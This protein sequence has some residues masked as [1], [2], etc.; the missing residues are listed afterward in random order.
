MFGSFRRTFS[1]VLSVCQRTV[2]SN[3]ARI[4]FFANNG[5]TGQGQ[6]GALAAAQQPVRGATYGMEYQP[7]NY[8]RK[9]RHGF[10]KRV[11]TRAG[12][13]ILKR[14]REKGRKFLSH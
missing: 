11:R 13:R 10:L 4:G 5:L 12:R 3:T 1:T 7:N 8:K 6:V 9:K 2:F 14:R